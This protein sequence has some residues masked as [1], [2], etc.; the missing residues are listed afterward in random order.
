MQRR[1]EKDHQFQAGY[2]PAGDQLI[3]YEDITARKVAEDSFKDSYKKLQ[4]ALKGIVT[5]LAVTVE[6]RDPYTAGHQQRVAS[7]ACA[8]AREMDLAE[9]QIEGLSVAAAVHDIGKINIPAELLS[10]PGKLS[11]MEFEIVKSHAEVSFA[12]LR[13]IEFPWPVALAVVQHHERMNGSGYPFG[14]SSPD[15]ILEAR[16][17]AVADVVEAMA[18]HR[19]Y[20][21]TLGIEK[22]LEEISLNRGILYDSEVVDACVRLFTEKGFTF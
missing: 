17:L 6:I 3:I 4:K 18:S 20:G 7:L 14:L 12:I 19:P 13:G 21:T 1:F 15:I 2:P 8:I 10:K 16:I 11:K 9:E 22:A 5:A